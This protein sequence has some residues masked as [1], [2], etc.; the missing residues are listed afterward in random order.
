STIESK[1]PFGIG[2]SI[3]TNADGTYKGSYN[4]SEGK[5]TDVN[6]D[7]LLG[8]NKEVGKFS[9]DASVG[10]NTARTEGHT[11]TEGSTNF[12]VKDLYSIGNGNVKSQSYTFGRNR[13]N[14][15]YG[16]AEIGYDRLLY[17]NFT[18][19]ED[20]FSVYNP[21]NNHVYYPSLSGSFIFSE[22]LP[23]QKWLNY[24]KLRVAWAKTGSANGV[25]NFEGLLNYAIGANNFNGQVTATIANTN[26]PNA[27]LT[28][29]KVDEK[30]IGLEMR[31]FNDRVHVDISA[32]EK[33]TTDQVLAVT[34]SNASGYTGSK[35]NLGS[36]RN[37]GLESL[38]EVTPVKSANFS[39]TTS[40]NNSYLATKTLAISPGVKDFLLLY[41]NGTGNEFLGQIHYTVGLPMNQL[42]T[43]T[44]L[45]DA[46]G[47]ILVSPAGRLLATP[48]YKPIG[49]SIPKFVG[50]WTNSFTYKNLS[51]G[52][53]FDYKFGGKVMS[54]TLLNLTRQG[55]SKLSLVGRRPGENGLVFPAINQGTGQPNTVAV[56]DLQG[57]Y[58]DYR[59]LQIGD[60]FV[61]KSDFIK[62][63]N[64]SIAYNL[65]GLINKVSYLK[66]FKG[67]SLSA[68]VRNVA[69]LYKDLPG[70]DPEAIQSSG[71]IRAGYEDAALPT[72]RSYNL[73]LN[74][75]F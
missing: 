48:D 40:W 10:G 59:N 20:W 75:K 6:A 60:P 32:F 24:G 73:S 54:S 23:A 1:F 12:V 33:L 28:P 30:E 17:I 38:I 29:F 46:K 25:N 65:T 3:P 36:L 62:L 22:L 63:R 70:L 8:A 37:T 31:M 41:F 15:L 67:L 47:N 53:F 35:E 52:I 72:T 69:I 19:R 43:R 14:S 51:L 7:F 44:Y 9:F 11:L 66:F 56:T 21:K 16:L 71:D 58:S 34:L 4:I 18:S 2:T 57:F 55:L 74:V 68:S 5:G 61:F 64:I 45:R 26:A 13:V 27:L 49:S 39:W 42:Y 50:G